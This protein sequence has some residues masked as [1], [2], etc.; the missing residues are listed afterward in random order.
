[1]NVSSVFP[2]LA[3]MGTKRIATNGSYPASKITQLTYPEA[4]RG[5]RLL[6]PR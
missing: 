5:E 6:T 4:D 3:A 1:M 2:W